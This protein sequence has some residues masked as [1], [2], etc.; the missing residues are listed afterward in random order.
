MNEETSYV[1]TK[2]TS[3]YTSNMP[4]QTLDKKFN[5]SNKNIFKERNLSNDNDKNKGTKGHYI[6]FNKK[7][8]PNCNTFES[9]T[10]TKNLS[11]YEN[12]TKDLQ[13]LLGV[14]TA[15]IIVCQY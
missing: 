11:Y 8:I 15:L 4:L 5:E 6:T 7:T 1:E 14:N 10:E 12:L 3:N 13:I 9:K 2:R